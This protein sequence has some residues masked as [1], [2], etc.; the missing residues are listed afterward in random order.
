[1]TPS[2]IIEVARN[3]LNAVADTLWSDTELLKNLYLCELQLA[4][5]TRCIEN[6]STTT[7]ISGTSDYAVP[8][9]AL[10]IK[11]ITYNGTRIDPISLKQYDQINPQSNSL[12][13][14]PT[15]YIQFDDLITLVPTPDTSALTIK[16]W[17]YSEPSVPTLVSTLST[18]TV[19]HDGLCD[20]LT[21]RMCPKDLGHPLTTF[22]RDKWFT[23]LSDAEANERRRKRGGG[24]TRVNCEEESVT[25]PLG[26]I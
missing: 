13:G 20:G 25:T 18:P 10:E 3:N 17:V 19:Y 21:Y 22:W 8:T 9:R 16:Y 7:S 15:Y 1:M 4:R 2:E 6:T 14:T 11:R 5:K 24:F 23:F 26:T 12:V